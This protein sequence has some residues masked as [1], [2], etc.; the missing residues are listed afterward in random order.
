MSISP[1]GPRE[2]MQKEVKEVK[3]ITDD[4]MWYEGERRGE[5]VHAEDPAVQRRVIEVILRIGESMR[6]EV[7]NELSH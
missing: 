5:Y 1:I 2:I 7:I 6:N 3:R 4:E